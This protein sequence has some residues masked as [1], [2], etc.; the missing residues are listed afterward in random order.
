MEP[1]V[2]TNRRY[3]IDR[4]ITRCPIE[5]RRLILSLENY[6]VAFRIHHRVGGEEEVGMGGGR[7]GIRALFRF[8]HARDVIVNVGVRRSGR[9]NRYYPRRDL[10][11]RPGDGRVVNSSSSGGENEPK[12]TIG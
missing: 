10:H 11:R 2:R 12:E 3:G 8:D 7:R 1:S 6:R 4:A 5:W 9:E